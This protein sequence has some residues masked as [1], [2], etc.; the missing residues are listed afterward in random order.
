MRHSASMSYQ[1]EIQALVRSCY[2]VFSRLFR[3][4]M[5]VLVNLKYIPSDYSVIP[6]SLGYLIRVFYLIGNV[7]CTPVL[8][9]NALRVVMM[10]VIDAG[11][12]KAV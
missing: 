5:L 2:N 10:L 6:D 3:Q 8:L 4:F 7:V 9:V 11:V 12:N 1:C